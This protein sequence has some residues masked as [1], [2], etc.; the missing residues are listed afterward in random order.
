[1]TAETTDETT[2]LSDVLNTDPE[3]Y[4]GTPDADTIEQ[5][6]RDG[7]TVVCETSDMKY[8]PRSYGV[9]GVHYDGL[10][11]LV[12]EAV[13]EHIDTIGSW[14]YRPD[15]L[16][17][18]DDVQVLMDDAHLIDNKLHGEIS[19]SPA[20]TVAEQLHQAYIETQQ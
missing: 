8:L 6:A 16:R 14:L 17:S 2:T 11:W 13:G 20:T 7:T 9:I 15:R 12:V 19:G 10:F 3:L 1:M 4:T 5:N 18:I